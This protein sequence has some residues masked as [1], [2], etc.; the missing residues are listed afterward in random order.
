MMALASFATPS[1]S[2]PLPMDR[3]VVIGNPVSHSLSPAIHSRF[4]A[5]THED[6]DYGALLAPLDDFAGVARR[7]FD[8]GGAGA[9]VTLP[10]KLDP[11]RFPQ[12][13]SD[14]PPPPAPP[15]FLPPKAGHTHPTT[16]T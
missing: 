13:A 16:P 12:R 6:L 5:Q 15:N 10:F 1:G 14:R 4:A 9:N 11:L 7:F 3:Y 8:E 2:P